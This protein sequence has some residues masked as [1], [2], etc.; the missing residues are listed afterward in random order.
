[1][2]CKDKKY[3]IV[4]VQGIHGPE[5]PAGPQGPAGAAPGSITADDVSVTNP[6]YNTVQE[7][8]DYLL[9]VPL[10]INSFTTPTTVY[11][12][13]TVLNSLQLNWTLNRDPITQGITG[14][15]I[16]TPPVL[17]P[18][19]RSVLLALTG[20]SAA[21]PGVGGTYV[22]TITDGTTTPGASVNVS[23]WNGFYY[24]DAPIPGVLDSAFINSLSRSLQL[25]RG[26][27]FI[28][29]AAGGDY[30]WFAHRKDLGLASVIVGGFS[31]GFEAPDTVAFT[32]QSG[33]TEDYYVYRSTNFNIGPIDVEVI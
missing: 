13:G 16:D 25:G 26:K 20:L 21:S 10:A 15:V 3:L 22:L 24:G 12:I 17:A 28:T 4:P 33:F 9:Y 11:E 31:G 1:M 8:L 23:F 29:N 18:A 19:D 27:T 30:A 6:G 7:V 5:G 2:S 32:N 14:P